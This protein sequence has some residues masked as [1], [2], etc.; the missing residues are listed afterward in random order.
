MS[1]SPLI[2]ITGVSFS[3]GAQR[4][5]CGIELTVNRG[6]FVAVIGPNGG[7]K[8]TLIKLVLGLLQPDRGVIKVS[9]QPPGA[10]G[11][12]VGYVPQHI[13][14]NHSFPATALDVVLMGL[15]RPDRRLARFRFFGHDNQAKRQAKGALARLGVAD[16]AHQRIRDL[17]GGQRQ[18]VLIARA[19]VAEPE[20]L[21]LDEPTASLD[22]R[23]QNDFFELLTEI[24]RECTVLVVSHDLLVIAS[25]AKSVACVNRTL[26]YHDHIGSS[27]ELMEAFYSS[28]TDGARCPVENLYQQLPVIQ[29]EIA[30]N[31]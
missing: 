12:L 8:T 22:T 1:V 27:D 9:D 3:Y 14:H 20:L 2:D 28:V 10:V 23:A 6:D 25:Y 4:V 18:R 30:P 19:L 29:K 16:L 24:N 21:I 15:F 5:L 17:S 13:D 31:V 26:H 7:G 11:G